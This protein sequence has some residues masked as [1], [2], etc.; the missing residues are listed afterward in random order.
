MSMALGFLRYEF[1]WGEI[2]SVQ[3]ETY[4][5]SWESTRIGYLPYCVFTSLIPTRFIV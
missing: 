4:W 5:Q 3:A 1:G 2:T